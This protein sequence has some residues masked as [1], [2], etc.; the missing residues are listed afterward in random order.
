MGP[1]T[2]QTDPLRSVILEKSG[3][4]EGGRGITTIARDMRHMPGR[5]LK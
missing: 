4:Q 5:L 3:K 2:R 1:G